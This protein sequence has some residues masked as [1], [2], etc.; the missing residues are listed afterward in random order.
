METGVTVTVTVLDQE[1]MP[2]HGAGVRALD[3]SGRTD[4][5]GRVKLSNLPVGLVSFEATSGGLFK[6]LERHT[7]TPDVTIQLEENEDR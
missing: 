7:S 5:K 3:R 4:A 2:F 6:V 1:G